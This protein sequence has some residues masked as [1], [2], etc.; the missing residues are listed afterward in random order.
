MVAG[1]ALQD[2]AVVQAQSHLGFHYFF[3]LIADHGGHGGLVVGKEQDGGAVVGQDALCL[4]Q[5][6]GEYFVQFQR[7]TYDPRDF[8]QCVGA[9]AGELLGVVQAS[10]LESHRRLV[11]E[12]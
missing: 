5:N 1:H 6:Q 7:G 9:L 2:R 8:T 10:I 11:S 3:I 4:T 12:E